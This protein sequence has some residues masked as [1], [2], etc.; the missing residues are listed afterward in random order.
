MPGPVDL[1]APSDVLWEEL[2]IQTED[3]QRAHARAKQALDRYRALFQE[4]PAGYLTLDHAG[5]VTVAHPLATELLG[6][7]A[8]DGLRSRVH[9][10]DLAAFEAHL[11]AALHHGEHTSCRIRLRSDDGEVL[12]NLDTAPIPV[13]PASAVGA[14]E[15]RTVVSLGQ[16]V[17]DPEE[18]AVPLQQATRLLDT[19]EGAI[20]L[21]ARGRVRWVSDSTRTLFGAEG[22]ELVGK[23]LD[24][25]FLG[26]GVPSIVAVARQ[27]EPGPLQA[28]VTARRLDRTT[29][30]ARIRI[31]SSQE[32][33][34]DG[35]LVVLRDRSFEQHLQKELHQAQ[36]MEAVGRFSA[37]VLVDIQNLLS[38]VRAA[39][40]VSLQALGNRNAARTP[41][42]MIGE[43][44]ESALALTRMV[45]SLDRG[46]RGGPRWIDLDARIRDVVPLFE[47]LGRQAVQIRLALEAADH[48]VRLDASGV[49]QV[50]LNLVTNA[51]EAMPE[52]GPLQVSTA[53][54]AEPPAQL[55]ASQAWVVLSVEDHG[56]GIA[57][58]LVE[59]VF[60][61]F[62]TTKLDGSG[63]GLGLSTVRGLVQEAG[64]DVELHSAVGQGTHVRVF[65]P[66]RRVGPVAREPDVGAGGRRCT[67][68]VVEGRPLGLVGMEHALRVAG[69]RVCA[70]GSLVDASW[71][72][73]RVGDALDALVLDLDLEGAEEWLA[74]FRADHPDLAT[75][76]TTADPHREPQ[77]GT[78]L[79]VLPVSA[80]ALVEGL[81]R[82]VG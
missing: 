20:D 79:L 80:E 46:Q 81:A 26:S 3:L 77:G 49:A 69:H 38:G 23:A 51:I 35:T 65:L 29:F 17:L 41:L 45:L 82:C 15:A 78:P 39:T 52:G 12:V 58:D 40:D 36:R 16:A 43:A 56:E 18:G 28:D 44:S 71:V 67:V 1:D 24:D 70:A 64:G 34:R 73:G 63:T 48:E 66:A 5:R 7:L 54:V 21:D 32:L 60:E 4:T 9:P 10:D 25:L 53:I 30:P 59:R 31:T 14:V 72:L 11:H 37:S 42:R 57:P 27:R 33:G 74:A 13:S 62:F 50:L 61:P 6:S 55:D 22:A 19:S 75:V 68:L 47:R 2:Q 8:G 76:F